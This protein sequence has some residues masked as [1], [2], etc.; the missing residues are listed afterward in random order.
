LSGFSRRNVVH[1]LLESLEGLAN[2]FSNLRQF[3]GAEND[4]HDGQNDD[5]F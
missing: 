1:L 5:Q 2:A 4:E 3:A